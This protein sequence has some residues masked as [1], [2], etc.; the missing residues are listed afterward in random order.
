MKHHRYDTECGVIWDLEPKDLDASMA[1]PLSVGFVL[2]RCRLVFLMDRIT[3]LSDEEGQRKHS[4]CNHT[5]K[6]VVLV[7]EN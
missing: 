5:P 4:A 1:P 2:K 3:E 6:S 7:F